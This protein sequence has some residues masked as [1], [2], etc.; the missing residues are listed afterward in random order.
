MF[1]TKTV[2]S[3]I[4]G[5][6]STSSKERERSADSIDWPDDAGIV[7]TA[8]LASVLIWSATREQDPAALEACLNSLTA[9]CENPGFPVDAVEGL[10][11]LEPEILSATSVQFLEDLRDRQRRGTAK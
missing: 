2:N 9:L 3:I 4:V 6:L 1:T 11:A 5:L 8:V 7:E 10:S